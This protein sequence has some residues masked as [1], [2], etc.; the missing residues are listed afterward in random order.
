MTPERWQQVK[1]VL[2]TVLEVPPDQRSSFLELN[3][4][5]DDSLRHDVEKLLAEEHLLG[6]D[7]LEHAAL[8][9]AV[10]ALLPPDDRIWIG[11]RVGPYKIVE[12]IG[13]GGMGEVYRAVRADDQ[14]QKEVALKVVRSGQFSGFVIDRFKNERQILASLDHPH[15]ARL[16]DGGATEDGTPYFVMEL[17]EGQPIT[18][19]CDYRKLSV[20][21]R[22]HLF[23][24]VCAAVQYAH[25][26]LI[27]HRDIKPGNIL[28]TAD[29]SPKLLDFGIAKIIGADENSPRSDMTLTAFRILTP[30]YASPEQIKGEPMTTASDVYSL[31]VVL[32]E[33]LTGCSPYENGTPTATEVARAVC[34]D[35]PERPSAAVRRAEAATNHGAP[36]ASSEKLVRQLCGDLD[37]IVLMALRKEP[38]RRYQS[39]EQL[40][41]DIRRHLEDVPVL[42]RTDT[43][44]Y[45]TSKFVSRHRFGVIASA[46]AACALLVGFTV[47]IYEA[48]AAR[49][50]AGIARVQRARAERRFNDVRKLANSLMFEIHDSIKD[51][52][53][54][55]SARKLL[56]NRALEYLDSLSKESSDDLSLQR[57]LA[58]AYDR[59]GDVLGYNGAANLGDFAGAMQSYKKALAIREA[60]AAAS[61]GDAQTQSDLLND[62]FHLGFAQQD[63]GD[64]K[65]ALNDFRKALP[66]AQGLVAAYPNNPKYQDWFAGFH[67]SIGNVLSR[68]GDYAGAL[69]S[70]RQG[71]SIRGP[72]AGDTGAPLFR[73]HLAADYQGVGQM[74]MRT[75]EIDQAIAS[76]RKAAQI[77]EQVSQSD[78]TNATVREFLGESYDTFAL[79]LER[80]PGNLEEALEYSR[81]GVKVFSTLVSADPTNSLARANLGFA[82]AR[83][84][85]VLLAQGKIE[86]ATP[87]ALRAIT[88]FERIGHKN[89]YDMAGQ[90]QAYLTWARVHTS[91]AA[92]AES[93]RKRFGRLREARTWLQ[94][95]LVTWQQE[96]DHSAL[97]P[98]GR[99]EGERIMQEL[100]KC[101]AALAKRTPSS[102]H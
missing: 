15:I 13:A 77:L 60:A 6:Q 51:L 42:A 94:K 29:G 18:Q 82:E 21:E 49:Q 24:K 8:A 41:E 17:I 23:S 47:A 89:R 76:S 87:H 69:A 1:D 63:A 100:A 5:G 75:G 31:G 55:T 90:A 85:D 43:T 78:P 83:V 99:E 33:L 50:Q 32:Y 28:V 35:E 58:A 68:T 54:T 91:L 44:W 30:R 11:R 93:S 84:G 80:R 27:V 22:L 39:V 98:F 34:E 12:L 71:L 96:P 7:F 37:N 52:P 9:P 16:L 4:A 40:A 57:E 20:D 26:H 66:V 70:Y 36:D 25:Q 61:P 46:V 92:K 56:V 2:A 88:T 45:R 38:P 14:Y 3:C 64:Y 102:S 59:V 74:L 48:R 97:D 67:W 101:N 72:I 81:K 53:G 19:F 65:G 62:Y 95:S 10:A 79:I 73:T 86:E